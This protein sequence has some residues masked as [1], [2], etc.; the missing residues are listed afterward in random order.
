MPCPTFYLA[1]YFTNTVARP[2]NEAKPT[3]SVNVVMNTDE[4]SAGSTF[5]AF[6]PSGTRVPAVAATN[7]LQTM[8][9]PSSRPSI[10]SFLVAQAT[11][12]ATVP[13]ASPF[14]TPMSASLAR[15]LRAFA[16]E[17][18]QRQAPHDHRQRLRRGV[19]PHPRHD[20]HEDGEGRDL[21]DRALEERH[22]R[23]RDEGRHQVD[24]EPRQAFAKGLPGRRRDALVAGNTRQAKQVLGRL[25]LDDV[26]DV[27]HR[28]HADELVLLVDDRHGEQVVGRD[29]ARD[30]LL[31]GVHAD[32][33][34]VGRH[35]ALQ[36]RLG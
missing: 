21:L 32:A 31:V 29:L 8:A 36:R 14:P 25:V 30:F 19:A 1:R 16:H 17:L 35:D 22:D 20:G 28:D 9:M 5:R 24:A 7:M 2:R 11:P 12:A 26:D 34:D 10:G 15:A 4:A 18:A 33:D 3:T 23:G 6:R 27:V 13:S